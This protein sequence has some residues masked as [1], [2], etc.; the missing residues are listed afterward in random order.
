MNFEVHIKLME[1]EGRS[2][3]EYETDLIN[4]TGERE[5]IDQELDGFEGKNWNK[6]IRRMTL[7][8]FMNLMKPTQLMEG[9]TKK[10]AVLLD[11]VQITSPPL[12]WKTCTTF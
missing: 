6:G 10:V 5:K 11:F 9:F 4:G 1:S 8:K 3:K 7:T 2:C 12:I